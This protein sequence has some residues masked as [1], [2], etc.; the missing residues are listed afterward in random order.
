MAPTSS[1]GG[2][3]ASTVDEIHAMVDRN[4]KVPPPQSY[5]VFLATLGIAVPLWVTVLPFSVLWGVTK[6]VV[7]KIL[8]SKPP[9][10]APFDSGIEVD[11]KDI[12]DRKDRKYDVVLMGATG[13]TGKL[14]LR[15]LAKNYGGKRGAPLVGDE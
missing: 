8:P 7:G 15:Y 11:P 4:G 10:N 14:A 1:S 2:T 5:A 6:A 13:F 12:K 9:D 3:A